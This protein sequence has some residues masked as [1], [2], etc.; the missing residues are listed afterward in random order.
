ME[1]PGRQ[2]WLTLWLDRQLTDRP[3]TPRRAARLIAFASLFLT[4]LGGVLAR[5]IDHKDFK[6]IGD[7]LWWALQTVTTVGYGDVVPHH[8]SG[9]ILGTVL[10]LNGI[11]F[12]SV[13]TAAITATLI[14][15]A[16]Q[17]RP[18]ADDPVL[19]AVKRV[20]ARLDAMEGRRGD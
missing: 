3:L 6:S 4:A 11:A 7:S 18:A 16:R 1:E 17:Q 8:T 10:M 20:E 2:E 15:R 12:L 14:E 9:R 19:A 13:I 5:V